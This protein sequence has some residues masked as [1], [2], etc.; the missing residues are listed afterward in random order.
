MLQKWQKEQK[1]ILKEILINNSYK[2]CLQSVLNKIDNFNGIIESEKDLFLKC[3]N[4]LETQK[5][6]VYRNCL[7][8]KNDNVT[9]IEFREMTDYN[10]FEKLLKEV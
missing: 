7:I 8:T 1:N 9:S 10:N 2:N 4:I 3:L 6:F 5:G